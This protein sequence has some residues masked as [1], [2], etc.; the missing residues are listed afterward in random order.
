MVQ[1][2]DPVRKKRNVQTPLPER[3]C[4]LGKT[5]ML[6]LHPGR[7]NRIAA[8]TG[9]EG[10][11]VDGIWARMKRSGIGTEGCKQQTALSVSGRPTLQTR[12]CPGG[13]ARL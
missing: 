6:V 1:D 2:G 4:W 10:G 8:M 12:N 3:P 13:A 11:E 7:I 9:R 5:G